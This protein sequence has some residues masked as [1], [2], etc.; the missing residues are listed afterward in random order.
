M[1]EDARTEKAW[2][3][4]EHRVTRGSVTLAVTE[5]RPR[6]IREG[7][8]PVTLLF[9]HGYPDDQTVWTA[10]AEQLASTFHVVTFDVRG[11]GKSTLPSA[12]SAYTLEELSAD[13]VAVAETI[14]SD[15]PVHLVGHD[16]GSIQAWEPVT[17]PKLHNHFK[18]FTSISGPCLDHIG[19][20]LRAP[21]S[22]KRARGRQALRSWYIAFFHLPLL[23]P[24][25]WRLLGNR[26]D[27]IIERSEGIP[28]TNATEHSARGANGLHGLS[29]Y[30]ANILPRLLAPRR[31][32]TAIPVQIL[33]PEDDAYVTPAL[34]EPFQ[35]GYADPYLRRLVPNVERHLIAGG[36][37]V[38]R[39]DPSSI[40]N[41]IEDF[42]TRVES[43]TLAA[44]PSP[45]VGQDA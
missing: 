35:E 36:H 16:W 20:S 30:R 27:A 1:M 12:I 42:V 21:A 5:R 32:S 44:I 14:R 29:L 7:A 28:S 23:A 43:G 37:W 25:V 6:M 34:T 24:L 31:R 45:V 26:F 41:R 19:Q 33:V 17:E 18:S 39:R 3:T 10:V 40:A 22:P 2:E 13:I 4:V 38:L 15:A 8:P 9:V 11:A